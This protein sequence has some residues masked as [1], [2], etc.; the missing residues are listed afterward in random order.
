MSLYGPTESKIGNKQD[1]AK[2][3][4]ELAIRNSTSLDFA[5]GIFPS[6]DMLKLEIK[7]ILE[8]VIKL[9]AYPKSIFTF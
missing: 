3:Y 7:T 4:I 2:A 6:L 9:S 1:A 8:Q 5:N